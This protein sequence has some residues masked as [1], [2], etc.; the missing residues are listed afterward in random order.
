M[1]LRT[2]PPLNGLR[3]FE[4]F[5]RH[6][7]MTLAAEEL[8]V[9]HGAVSR[10]IKGLEASLGVR[11][12]EGPRSG[13]R[14]TEA[15]RSLALALSPLF[16]G[17]ES[18]VAQVA[19]AARRLEVA[20]VSTIATRW[21]IPRLSGFL[22]Q[23]PGVAV[24]LVDANGPTAEV[25]VALQLGHDAP[26]DAAE[27]TPFKARHHGPVATPSKLSA[28]PD[29]AEILA[30]PRLVARTYPDEWE[31][32]ARGFGIALPAVRE[33]QVFDRY[34][35]AMGAATAGIGAT[36]G[37]WDAVRSEIEAGTL[38]APLGFIEAPSP[39]VF[40]RG[41]DL[42]DPL[43]DSFRDWLVEEG[44]RTP[45]PPDLSVPARPRAG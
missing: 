4:V 13:M 7:R 35:H 29:L 36:I 43:A 25:N 16:E 42:R 27:V 38:V 41:R 5:A 32:W 8:C 20:C 17:L 34:L 14:L 3:A 30:L 23:N 19:P 45:P 22:D 6:G 40:V 12:L 2:L 28:A 44:A 1:A 37:S 11:L 18:A 26:A 39:C 10:Q 21:L 9:T 24:V 15:G 31:L 33:V